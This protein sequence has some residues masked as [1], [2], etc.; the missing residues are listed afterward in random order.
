MQKRNVFITLVTAGLFATASVSY[1]AAEEMSKPAGAMGS[2]KA[3]VGQPKSN[4]Y[5]W[6]D[7]LDL[8]ALRDHDARS[9]PMGE[10]FD[11]AAEFAN[12]ICSRQE[13]H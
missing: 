12:W 9:N 4:Q 11:Y 6:P 2:G 1:S 5:W 8:S 13:G 3:S 10:E 7:Q